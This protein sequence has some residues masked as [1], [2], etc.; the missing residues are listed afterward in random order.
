ML[1]I[2]EIKKRIIPVLR[3]NNVRGAV[4]FGSYAKGTANEDSDVDLLLDSDL[5]GFNFLSLVAKVQDA[6]NLEHADIFNL[7]YVKEHEKIFNE[8]IKYGVLIYGKVGHYKWHDNTTPQNNKDGEN[9]VCI[10]PGRT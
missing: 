10:N 2:E 9:K 3:E 5:R 7:L 8:I 4:L 1:T 6:L